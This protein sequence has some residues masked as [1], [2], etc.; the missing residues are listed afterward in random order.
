[1]QSDAGGAAPAPQPQGLHQNRGR[2]RRRPRTVFTGAQLDALARAFQVN[3]RPG[4]E[5][6]EELARRIAAPEPRVQVWFQ[7]RRARDPCR[8]SQ[9]GT[10]HHHAPP[11]PPGG[12]PEL[13]APPALWVQLL[14]GLRDESPLPVLTEEDLAIL[15]L[16]PERGHA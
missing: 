1:M 7:N 3:P 14:R 12:L 2:D 9:H 13:A 4:F 6:R 8:R 15:Q 10:P 16:Q 5:A 11:P